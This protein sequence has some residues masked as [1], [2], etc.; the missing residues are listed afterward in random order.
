MQTVTTTAAMSA[1]GPDGRVHAQSWDG[2]Q[3]WRMASAARDVPSSHRPKQVTRRIMAVVDDMSP[4]IARRIITPWRAMHS[5]DILAGYANYSEFENLPENSIDG[6]VVPGLYRP[7]YLEQLRYVG[8]SLIL[9][10]DAP[11]TWTDEAREL[12]LETVEQYDG[13]IVPTELLAS[14]FRPYHSR[15]FVVPHLL[16]GELYQNMSRPRRPQV[17]IGIPEIMPEELRIAVQEMKQHFGERVIWHD[18]NWYA[19]MPEQEPEFYQ[20]LDI[21]I[22][23]QPSDRYQGSLAPLLPAFASETVILAERS[24]T[25]VKHMDTGYLVGRDTT[26]NWMTAI[27]TLAQDSRTRMRIGRK[28]RSIARRFTPETKLGQLLL[29]YR[30]L[31]PEGPP[32]RYT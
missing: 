27:K 20:L 2:G 11:V 10:V 5:G 30:L 18:V 12:L 21:L 7:E 25:F 6:V 28:A 1:F 22:L 15:V 19:Q 4:S 31:V 17:H 32:I 3:T 8:K 29:P 24:W 23:P 16:R 14:R 26:Q 9:D 13:V